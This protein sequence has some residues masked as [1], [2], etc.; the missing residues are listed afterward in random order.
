MVRDPARARGDVSTQPGKAGGAPL[1]ITAELPPDIL[2]W[3]D[4]LRRLHYPPERNRLRAHVTLFHGLPPSAEGEVRRLLGELAKRP[5]VDAG[6]SGIWNMGKGTAFDVDS[7]DMEELHALMRERFAGIM[8]AQDD[9]QLR[10]HI[11]VQNKVSYEAA[12]QLQWEL[13]KGFTPRSF[14]FRGFGLYA[15]EE[16]LWRPIA[17]YPFRH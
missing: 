10:I 5:P 14:R 4:D 12:R 17:E 9:R 15:W 3:A 11:T 6:I 2:A 8:S 13:K 7:P 16:G 1:L